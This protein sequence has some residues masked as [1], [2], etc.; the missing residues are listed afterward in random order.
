MRNMISYTRRQKQAKKAM[1]D[2]LSMVGL[3]SKEADKVAEGIL[4]RERIERKL[5]SDAAL[6]RKIYRMINGG[7]K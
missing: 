7:T 2:A 6:V 4:E 5:R 3:T 1:L